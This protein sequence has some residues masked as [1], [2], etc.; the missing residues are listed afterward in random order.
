MFTNDS[1]EW[2]QHGGFALRI[3]SHNAPQN[4]MT[5]KGISKWV[6]N[7]HLFQSEET[8]RIESVAIGQVASDT[9]N[10]QDIC[11]SLIKLVQK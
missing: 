1:C 7:Q 5:N 3:M 6:S 8:Q 2:T 11:A 4:N 10:A 9:Q